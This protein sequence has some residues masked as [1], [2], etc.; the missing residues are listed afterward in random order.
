METEL[1]AQAGVD[2]ETIPAAGVHGVGLKTLPGNLWRLMRG[3]FAARKLLRRFQPDVM[4]FTGGYVAVPVALAGLRTPVALYVPDIEPG[5]A[6]KT[7]TRFADRITVTTDDSREYFPGHRGVEVAGYPNR[8]QLL[9]F[10]RESA[11]RELNLHNDLPTLL[12]FGGS[13]GARSINQALFA[14]LPVL[15][16]EM[17][18]VHISGTA[19]WSEVEDAKRI[20]DPQQLQR[21]RAYPYLHAE[22]GAALRSADLV[23][24]RAG[25]S[26]LGE[27]PLFGLPAILVPYP[28]AW[29]Y[30]KTNAEYLVRHGAALMVKDSELPESITRIV[31][32]LMQDVQRRAEMRTAMQALN[33]PEASASIARVL[34]DLAETSAA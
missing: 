24:S 22:M 27:F 9:D 18:I 12:V 30:Q 34:M 32:D 8:Q 28:H 33:Q 5:L 19:N 6:L 4:F 14:A 1:I 7:L 26:C 23:L 20:L 31:I 3:F 2:F 17:Q 25:A 21:Y 15:L 11:Q 29:R 16:N 10:D 13:K